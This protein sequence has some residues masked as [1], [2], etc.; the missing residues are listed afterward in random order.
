MG[1]AAKSLYEFYAAGRGR[2]S[3]CLMSGSCETDDDAMAVARCLASPDT[4]VEVW[5][6][7]GLI[8]RVPPKG[9]AADGGDHV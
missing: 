5:L 6:V 9:E 3:R 7:D 2:H 8:G 1:A 4:G